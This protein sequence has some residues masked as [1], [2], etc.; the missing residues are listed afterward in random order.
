MNADRRHAERL[1]RKAR[2]EIKSGFLQAGRRYLERAAVATR[3]PQIRAHIAYL[4]AQTSTNEAS[5]RQH[6]EEAL[7]WDPTH[8][9]ARRALAMLER[10]LQPNEIIDP[11]ALPAP[12]KEQPVTADRFTCPQC[13]DRLSYRP[14]GRSLYCASCASRQPV[15]P[16]S[17]PDE[18]DFFVGMARQ[19]GHQA[20]VATQ[21]FHCQGCGAE[22]TLP[23]EK[24]SAQCA[25][26]QSPHV[27]SLHNRRDL[28]AP[29]GLIP[30][31]FTQAQARRLL[32]HW[33]QKQG[34]RP[35]APPP[36]LQALY[37]PAWTFDLVGALQWRGMEAT[38]RLPAYLQSRKKKVPRKPASGQ[39]PIYIDDLILPAS[40]HWRSLFA[41]LLP[42]YRLEAMQHYQAA[43]LADWPAALYDLPLAQASLQAREAA[44]RQA[45]QNARRA[46]AQRN[47]TDLRFFS[48]KVQI[49]SYKLI[50]LPLWHTHWQ[51][52]GRTWPLLLNGQTGQVVYACHHTAPKWFN[53]LDDLFKD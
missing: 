50:L 31:R 26:C 5:Q 28:L 3:N 6:L 37:L 19:S 9:K 14:D 40:A 27:V 34:L 35:K 18:R 32:A 29:A 21:I 20:P 45:K 17:L 52:R 33:A 10:Q 44:V 30:H 13:G 41:R 25:W 38:T 46:L 47:L 22:F 15:Q 51:S 2:M 1:V 42:S 48:G 12:S 53:W 16:T 43:Y 49:T 11:Q 7:A 8:P 23:P 36:P 24:I 39:L 4:F